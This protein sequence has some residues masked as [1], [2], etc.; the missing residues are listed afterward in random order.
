MVVCLGYTEVGRRRAALTYNAAVC[1]TGDGVLGGT[2]RC[3]SRSASRQAYAAGDGFDAFDTPVG[4]MGMLI[5]Y[6]KTF[7]EAAR[8]LAL[9]A[10][11]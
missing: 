1:L 6:D 10:P 7:P 2:A 8:S 11:R 3:T 9:T 5:D 4:R